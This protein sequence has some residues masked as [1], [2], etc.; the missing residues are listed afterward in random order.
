MEY[1]FNGR[2]ERRPDVIFRRCHRGRCSQV[3]HLCSETCVGPE[4]SSEVWTND[5]LSGRQMQ[6]QYLDH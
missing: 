3:K 5:F 1:E 6:Y 4:S 2:S